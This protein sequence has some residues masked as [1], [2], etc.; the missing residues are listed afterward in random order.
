VPEIENIDPFNPAIKIWRIILKDKIYGLR[1]KSLVKASGTYHGLG[2]K[3]FIISTLGD[4]DLPKTMLVNANLVDFGWL[5]DSYIDGNHDVETWLLDTAGLFIDE[6]TK[7]VVLEDI[8]ADTNSLDF[9]LRN[10]GLAK[11]QLAPPYNPGWWNNDATRLRSNN[12]Y[13]YGCD[14]ATNTFA[15][16]GRGSGKIYASITCGEVGPAAR[17]DGL[18]AV[19][20]GDGNPTDG[21]YAALVVGVNWDFHWCRK[22]RDG[23]WSHK[24]GNTPVINHDQSGNLITDP[25]KANRGRYTEFC[26]FYNVIPGKIRI[27]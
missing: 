25:R 14:Y 23:L 5:R 7:K 11:L 18:V 10:K 27:Q 2:Y 8:N 4:P 9:L 16:P 17:R 22:D 26:G 12:C 15:Q 13:N 1:E 6:E 3:G 20:N 21:H 19:P 24:P